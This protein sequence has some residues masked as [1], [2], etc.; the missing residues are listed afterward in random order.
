M[1]TE[2]QTYHD[3]W[4]ICKATPGGER[5]Q[6]QK[7]TISNRLVTHLSFYLKRTGTQSPGDEGYHYQIYSVATDTLLGSVSMGQWKDISDTGEWIEGELGTPVQIDEEVRICVFS[8]W[9]VQGQ[10]YL[11][12]GYNAGSVKADEVYTHTDNY[13]PENWTDDSQNDLAY[14]YTY[15]EDA[16]TVTTQAMTNVL[17]TS[18]TGNGTIVSIGAAAVTEHG[19]CWNTTG[20]PT[21]SDNKTTNGAGSVG[22]FT[23]YL[24]SLSPVLHY[25]VR[26]YA[27]NVYGTSYGAEVHFMTTWVLAPGLYGKQWVWVDWNDD[28]SFAGTYDDITA[29]V[30]EIPDITYGKER[31][32]DEAV[33]AS[34]QLLVYNGTHKYSPPNTSSVLNTGGNTLRAGHKIM[35]GQSFPF[36]DFL[37]LDGT[38]IASH[39]VPYD[40]SFTWLEESGTFVIDTN[41]VKETGGSGGIAVIDFEESDAHVQVKFK[42][43]A[44]DDCILVVRFFDINNYIYL[45]TTS[46]DLELRK[47]VATSDSLIQ[48]VTH[49]WSVGDTKIIKIVLHGDYL[50]VIVDLVQ[51]I[52]DPATGIPLADNFNETKTKYG[53]GGPSIHANA[54]YDDFGGVYSLFYGTIDSI[55]PTPSKERQTA[56][57]EAS[58]DMKIMA[59][60]M[61][62]RR[63]YTHSGVF[64]SFKGYLEE[65]IKSIPN[66]PQP[67][68]IFDNGESVD[69]PFKSWWN[70]SALDACREVEKEENGLFYQDRDGIWRFEAK[71]HR[72]A[73]PHDAA[74]CTFYDVY[75]TNNLAFTD[76]KWMSGDENV[77]NFITVTLQRTQAD[78]E[79]PL[80]VWRCAEADVLDGEITDSTLEIAA[81]SSVVIFMVAEQFEYI[82]LIVT[83]VATTD[84]AANAAADGSGVDKTANLSVAVA[85]P[86]FGSYGKGARLTLTNSDTSAIFV[87]RLRIRALTALRLQE[88][89]SVLAE[90]T[91]SQT[92]Y[93]I[94]THNVDARI[95]DTRY[96]AQTLADDIETKEDDPRATVQIVLANATKENLTKILSLQLSDRVTI[97]YSSMG[98]NEDFYINKIQYRVSNGGLA[99]E[100]VLTLIEVS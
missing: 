18:A 91:T 92:T 9:G 97:N 93:G 52:P 82:N 40:S 44:D 48:G 53:I 25:Y 30:L 11:S 69:N 75:A 4:A 73:T 7:L 33:P 8:P 55:I 21:T 63:V 16:P 36:D 34:L 80:E 27:T 32:L 19:H 22:A 23:S 94:R 3:S 56:Q 37:D 13:P 15:S 60:T 99:V 58:D 41:A 1:P 46:T 39:I 71:G 79:S 83:P 74:R 5:Y 68:E 28:G 86:F 78:P 45:K 26:A 77:K 24:Y 96:E 62:F 12:V 66:M 10:H 61:L 90:D 2:E 42:K 70:I 17:P 50:W 87:T 29:D 35:A 95:L 64:D 57:I 59:R 47:V 85:Y 54:R 84:Y 20:S 51:V 76:L 89:S 81:S 31:E 100:A 43:G 14:I 65:I 49:A 72:A 6:G 88:K 38:G 67:G 98:I